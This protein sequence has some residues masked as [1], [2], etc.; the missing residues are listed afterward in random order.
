MLGIVIR[1][2]KKDHGEE[3]LVGLSRAAPIVGASVTYV[4]KQVWLWETKPPHRI[5]HICLLVIIFLMLADNKLRRIG[6]GGRQGMTE[7]AVCYL[8]RDKEA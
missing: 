8:G 2:N 5:S 3:N 1:R 4:V 6:P 7:T